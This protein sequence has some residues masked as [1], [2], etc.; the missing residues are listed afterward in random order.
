M[1]YSRHSPRVQDRVRND[2]RASLIT[3]LANVEGRNDP[4]DNQPD[5]II[6]ELCVWTHPKIKCKYMCAVTAIKEQ[7]STFDQSR[8]RVSSDPMSRIRCLNLSQEIVQGGRHPDLCNAWGPASSPFVFVSRYPAAQSLIATALSS[9]Q[10]FGIT[11][12]P[13]GM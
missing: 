1:D 2:I 6:P 9:Y 10:I 11:V 13:F 7:R 5:A 12:V 8:T 3:S 4:D